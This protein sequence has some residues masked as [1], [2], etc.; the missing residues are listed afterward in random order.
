MRATRR[1]RHRR[2]KR[3]PRAPPA[4]TQKLSWIDHIRVA[5]Q[6]GLGRTGGSGPSLSYPAPATLRTT[7]ASCG[8]PTHVVFC[9]DL[10]LGHGSSIVP[11]R[12][13]GG[14]L[15]DYMASL[16]RARRARGRRSS[17]PA[18]ARGSPTRRRRSPSTSPHRQERERKLVAGARRRR[19]RSR[20]PA[21]RGLGRRPG[22]M[23][24]P[25]RSRCRPTSRSSR[26]RAGCRTASGDNHP[27]PESQRPYPV[28]LGGKVFKSA[29]LFTAGFAAAALPLRPPGCAGSSS[30]APCRR[31]RGGCR[32]MGSRARSRSAATAGAFRTSARGR[33]RD[34]WFGQGFCLGQDRLWQ[35]HIYR[36]LACGRI[37][38]FGGT[39]GLPVDRLMRTLGLH[40]TALR[41]VPALDDVVADG[42]AAYSAGINAAAA[43]R[44]LPAEFQMLRTGFEPWEPADSLTIAKLL[45]FGLST[46]WERE[47]LRADM[48]RELGEE[49]A[50]KLDPGY[51]A[52]N[53]I[54]LAPGTEH[55]G[56][57]LAIAEQIGRLRKELGF[58]VEATG[59][60]NWAVSA[61][62]SATG[63]AA[64][65]RRPAP[66]A[67]HA[68]HH[69]PGG[70][71]R[72]RPVRA[73][74]VPARAPRRH[75]RPEQR[76]RLDL[77]ERDG[78]RARPL[79]RA[80]RRRH[81][82]VRRREPAA[83]GDRGGD[84]GEGPRPRA[85][86]G[87][88]DPPRPDRERGARR[89]R[90]RAARPELGG[91]ALPG[92]ERRRASAF[93]KRAAAPS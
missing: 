44:P 45:A 47:L 75:L 61:E 55:P 74:R 15:A 29:G 26:T 71:V 79:R 36:E 16:E 68:G 2:P 48:A 17:V 78:G 42:L 13:M 41:E 92:G 11:P 53:P 76:R 49:L 9:G 58:A 50:V 72:G 93:S 56:D 60:N 51:P 69:L 19:A 88:R 46:N 43:Q 64:D 22:R 87:P 90:P 31:R 84:R 83:R 10:V 5:G 35:L 33:T 80:D 54:V 82:R 89:R 21:R 25:P 63:G 12:A 70:P 91:P 34:L 85:P 8:R 66:A 23:R 57:G 7:C 14:S 59:S 20:P 27:A 18:T 24:P 77:H 37:A 62:R 6:D 86:G 32:S 39:E 1:A 4:E 65:R 30:S 52:R 38:A 28:A 81:V 67:E 73:R 40:R 3:S